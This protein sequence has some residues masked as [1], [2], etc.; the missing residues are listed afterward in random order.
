MVTAPSTSKPKSPAGT[1]LPKAIFGVDVK[2]YELIQAAYQNSLANRRAN[3]AKTKKRGEV[4][5]GGQ[6][7]WSQKGTGRARFGSSRNPIWRGGGVAFGPTGLENYSRQLP[8]QAKQTAI[9]QALSLVNTSHRL[10]IINDFKVADGKTKTAK[11]SL[12]KLAADGSVLFVVHKPQK[13][14]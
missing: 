8:K 12:G 9:R 7:P 4:S 14:F 2:N 1:S 5:G 13:I 3:Y 11:L 6:K 10:K